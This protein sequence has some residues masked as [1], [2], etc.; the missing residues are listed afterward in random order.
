MKIEDG[1]AYHLHNTPRNEGLEPASKLTAI[2]KGTKHVQDMTVHRTVSLGQELFIY[3]LIVE[4]DVN[5]ETIIYYGVG[6]DVIVNPLEF[7]AANI[8]RHTC[9]LSED[10]P[11]H[12][13]FHINHYQ[14]KND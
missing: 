1:D 8:F 5:G 7:L 4:E 12:A 10:P 9:L 14:H 6:L 3:R 13:S 2:L 11:S